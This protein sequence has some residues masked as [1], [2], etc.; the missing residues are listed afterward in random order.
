MNASLIVGLVGI[1]LAAGALFAAIWSVLAVRYWS[2]LPAKQAQALE[3][4]AA[5]L[6]ERIGNL[7]ESHKRLRSRVGMR[8]LRKRRGG[9][10][11]DPEDDAPDKL[12]L[13]AGTASYTDYKAKLRD[14]VGLRPGQPAPNVKK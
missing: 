4:L 13:S 14:K 10:D 12:D 7:Y 3:M 2:G 8:E 1:F 5:E 6:D 9:P 11:Y